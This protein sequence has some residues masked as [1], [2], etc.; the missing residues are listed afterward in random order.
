M[1][2]DIFLNEHIEAAKR[3][4][5]EKRW[6]DMLLEQEQKD[7]LSTL[8]ETTRNVPEAER[9]PIRVIQDRNKMY[10]QHRGF[11]GGSIQ[12]YFPNVTALAD[13]NLIDIRAGNPTSVQLIDIKTKGFSY[14]EELKQ[15]TREPSQRLESELR[16]YI[17]SAQFRNRYPDAYRKWMEAEALLWGTD[18]EKQLTTIGHHCR[19]AMQDFAD[20]LVKTHKPPNIDPDKA[21]TINRLKAVTQHNSNALGQSQVQFLTTLADYWASV[22]GLV[23]RQVHGMQKNR[24]LVWEDG[25]RVVFQTLVTMVEIDR[26]LTRASP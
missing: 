7:L 6:G 11:S 15:E 9:E 1:L 5:A 22:E 3:L 16:S 12:V 18:P 2:M 24:D 19:E 23:Q 10:L 4:V 14:Y 20:V 21:H 26:A 17:D 25:R 13:A 8:V